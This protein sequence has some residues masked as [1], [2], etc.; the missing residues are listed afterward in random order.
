MG[1]EVRRIVEEMR[2]MQSESVRT[3]KA[4]KAMLGAGKK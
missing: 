1:K 3:V 2:E 4:S